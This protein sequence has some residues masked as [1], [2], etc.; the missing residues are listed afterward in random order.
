MGPTAIFFAYSDQ[1]DIW[2]AE[3]LAKA[4]S[5]LAT[6]PA[7]VPLG[8]LRSSWRWAASGSAQA[9]LITLNLYL[10]PNVL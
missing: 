10:S 9:G 3:K 8:V 2:R 5:W 4:V 1:D 6:I 7:E